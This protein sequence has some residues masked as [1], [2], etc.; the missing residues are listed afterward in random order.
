[1]CVCGGRHKF[2]TVALASSG[3]NHEKDSKQTFAHARREERAAA[4]GGAVTG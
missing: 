1:M 3:L 4:A 2:T